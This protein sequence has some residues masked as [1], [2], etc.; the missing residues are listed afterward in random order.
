M[1]PCHTILGEKWF[2]HHGQSAHAPMR[3][4]WYLVCGDQPENWLP[5]VIGPCSQHQLFHLQRVSHLLVFNL[6]R[7][8]VLIFKTLNNLLY[9]WTN[10]HFCNSWRLDEIVGNSPAFL[11]W[12]KITR[13]KGVDTA[14]STLQV[15]RWSWVISITLGEYQKVTCF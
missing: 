8:R 1:K 11:W 3:W 6:L 2:R 9:H 12:R 15:Y 4:Y 7:I 10:C 13:V 14:L 5:P